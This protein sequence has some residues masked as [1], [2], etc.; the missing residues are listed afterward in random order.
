MDATLQPASSIKAESACSPR[1]EVASSRLPKLAWLLVFSVFCIPIGVLWDIS[2]HST[3]GRDT[4][5]T[6]AHLVIYIGGAVPGMV[7]GWIALRTHFF[8]SPEVKA[9]SVSVLGLRAPIGAWLTIWGSIGM[10]T[11]APFDDW[12]H[13]A[14]G[15]DVKILSPPHTLLA[16]GMYAVAFG[17]LLQMLS[18]QNRLT[19]K[20]SKLAGI[21]FQLTAGVMLCMLTIFLTEKSQP[22]QMRSADFFY[23]IAWQYPI[24]LACIRRSARHPWA[25]SLVALTYMGI[26]LAMIWLLP[27]FPGEPKLA[28]I[29]REVTHMV[30]PAWPLLII[31]PAIALDLIYRQWER[32]PYSLLQLAGVMAA[33]YLVIL[34]PVQWY[35]SE[36]LISP[37]AEQSAFFAGNQ[38]FP[39][40]ST[41]GDWRYKF[42]VTK[43]SSVDLKVLLSSFALALISTRVG[44]GVGGWMTK[45]RR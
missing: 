32:K 10:L 45:V 35:F 41:R 23:I 29:Y 19:G 7:S 4:F 12:W 37:T 13:N 9:Q 36:F 2:W 43:E 14:Y 22:N 31:L 33:V 24:L 40:Y 6:P 25:C 8:G 17:V 30:P 38:Q 18:W 11:S 21:F 39:Y 27:L 34:L 44:L 20:E 16:L 28:P 26:Q 3:I 1:A 15:L 42:W 5:W